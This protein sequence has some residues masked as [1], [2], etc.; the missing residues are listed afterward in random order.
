MKKNTSVLSGIMFTA[1]IAKATMLKLSTKR[2][3]GMDEPKRNMWFL[4]SEGEPRIIAVNTTRDNAV[5]AMHEFLNY[6]NFKSY[7]T[8]VWTTPAGNVWFDVGSHTEFFVWGEPEEED[9]V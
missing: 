9:D 5:Q 7:Y 6:C 8:R 2:N 3:K 4:P 1:R